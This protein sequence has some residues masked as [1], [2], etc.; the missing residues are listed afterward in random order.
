MGSLCRQ[1]KRLE[2]LHQRFL[3]R[4]MGI[5]WE[6]KQTN[7]AV[8]RRAGVPSMHAVLTQRRLRWIGHVRRMD[9]G[10]IPK[11]IFYGELSTG[12]RS[13]GRP[14]LRFKDVCKRDMKKCGISIETWE[15]EAEDRPAWRASV[16][17]GIARLEEDLHQRAEE[18]RAARHR[19]AAEPLPA[20]APQFV[21][22]VG[23]RVC[24]AKIGLLSH[25]RRCCARN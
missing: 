5:T 2:T 14:L 1:E 12:T 8:L 16:K 24:R 7:E 19:R 11:D 4:I 21:C 13:V 17:D 25:Q 20:G 10:R 9:D 3:R 15:S 18:A 22:G 23:G 6:D